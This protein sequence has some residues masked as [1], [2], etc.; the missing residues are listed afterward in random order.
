MML[1]HREPISG[2]GIEVEID[3]SKFG[4]RKYYRGHRV[5]GQSIFGGREK[6]KKKKVFMLPVHDRKQKTLIPLIQ[7]W[8]HPA[9]VGNPIIS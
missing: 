7:K 5:E 1:E 4:K 9:T 6:Y 8:I 3:E 2:N